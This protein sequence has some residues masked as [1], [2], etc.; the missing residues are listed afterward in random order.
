[1]NKKAII[2]T[3]AILILLVGASVI[4]FTMNR[5]SEAETENSSSMSAAEPESSNSPVRNVKR[6]TDKK[7]N[8]KKVLLK[9]LRQ[10][11]NSPEA[12]ALIKTFAEIGE[13]Y[14]LHSR[15]L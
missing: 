15:V 7:V 14:A 3:V 4:Y 8:Q 2:C 9:Q 11:V 12:D 1:M 10:E 6:S 13:P 5:S